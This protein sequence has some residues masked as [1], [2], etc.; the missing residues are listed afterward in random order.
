MKWSGFLYS[1]IEWYV[2][3]TEFQN[4]VVRIP[5]TIEWY[6]GITEFQ[7]EVVRVPSTMGLQVFP[8]M[9]RVGVKFS[10]YITIFP[11]TDYYCHVITPYIDGVSFTTE[12]LIM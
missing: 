1:T 10:H 2:G 8:D 5:S 3:I 9:C 4:E 12:E 11:S 6:V 7:N